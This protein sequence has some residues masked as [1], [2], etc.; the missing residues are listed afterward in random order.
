MK[1]T[2]PQDIRPALSGGM[3]AFPITD[4]TPTG[5]VAFDAFARRVEWMC[6]FGVSAVF[7]GAGA[8]E[9]FS[10]SGSECDELVRTA[11]AATPPGVPVFA[12]V[13]CSTQEA[14]A[15]ARRAERSGAHGI[16][17]MPPYL[18]RATQDGLF[19]HIKAICDAVSIAVIVYS[20]ANC[21]LT[22]DTVERLAERCP[23]FAG[24]KDGAGD[25]EDI[26]ST[27]LALGDRLLFIN[28]MPTAEVF[29]YAYSGMGITTYSSGIFNF[30]PQIAKRFH[31]A[32]KH[33]DRAVSDLILREFLRPY[34][35]IRGNKPGYA[36][37]ILRAGAEII[38]RGAGPARPPLSE[39]TIDEYQ[40]LEKLIFATE[41]LTKGDEPA[42]TVQ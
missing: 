33:G 10:L 14:A 36:V 5:E 4:F 19:Q 30:I 23:N 26:L 13:G 24:F 39:I 3:L 2:T 31:N 25:V 21:V 15:A 6:G 9:F 42:E 41:S 22:C 38:G 28:G 37:T 7:P 8:G 40:A 32:L 27:R 11:L 35:G 29:A 34:L 18:T 17:L 1:Q 12:S 20:R 16:L